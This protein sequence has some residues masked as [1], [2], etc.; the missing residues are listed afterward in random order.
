MRLLLTI[1]C[2]LHIAAYANGFDSKDSILILEKIPHVKKLLDNFTLTP[3]SMNE[4]FQTCSEYDSISF[5]SQYSMNYAFQSCAIKDKSISDTTSPYINWFLFQSYSGDSIVVIVPI[6]GHQTFQ[7]FQSIIP[8][9]NITA[10]TTSFF[11]KAW[12]SHAVRGPDNS[13]A[14]ILSR[15][16][17]VTGLTM[18]KYR[19]SFDKKNIIKN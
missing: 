1:V 13:I 10:D 14:A 4:I 9:K 15:K 7:Q 16:K 3:D 2:F 8:I 18:R 11:F 17:K 6:S 12:E 19:T 5:S